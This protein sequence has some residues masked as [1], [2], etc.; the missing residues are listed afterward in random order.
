MSALLQALQFLVRSSHTEYRSI[1]GTV[2]LNAAVL[3]DTRIMNVSASTN[4]Y[5]RVIA[6]FAA[7]VVCAAAIV[8]GGWTDLAHGDARVL[9]RV[10]LAGS[11]TST[12]PAEYRRVLAG[13]A[14]GVTAARASAR[15]SPGAK[16]RSERRF[17]AKLE[18]G[19]NA[20]L[21]AIRRAARAVVQ[22][23][24]RVAAAVER[25][26]GQIDS[27]DAVPGTIVAWVPRAA[28]AAISRLPGVTTVNRTSRPHAMATALVDGA[29]TWHAAGFAGQAPNPDNA[30][31]D[32]PDVVV[33]DEGITTDHVAFNSR[34]PADCSTCAGT[35][36][37]KDPAH[38]TAGPH[39]RVFSAAGRTDFSG[40]PHG[41]TIAASIASTDFTVGCASCNAGL[42]FG[43]DNLY[44]TWQ[45]K[46]PGLWSLGLSYQGEPGVADLPEVF[47]YSAGIYN[48]TIGHDLSW[49]YV[50]GFVNDMGVQWVSSAGN[51]GIAGPGYNGCLNGMHRVSTPA[52]LF[53]VLSVGG[54]SAAIPSDTNSWTV[55]PNSST[56]PTWDGRKKPDLIARPRGNVSH[57]KHFDV[58]SNGKLD[59]YGNNGDGTSYAAP[60][61]VAG[62]ALLA[63][64]GIYSPIAQR[65]M[66]INTA[67]PIQG[68][69]YWTPTSGWGALNL[70]AAFHQRG[71]WAISQV[72]GAGANSA[73]FFEVT[74]VSAGDRTT[75]AWNRR[76]SLNPNPT[77][78]TTGPGQY[79]AL[80]NLDLSQISPADQ[81]GATVTSTGGS[82][83]A[84][85][86]DI[87]QTASGAPGTNAP[88]D[89]P[90]PGSGVDGE[91]NVEQI[92]S[93]SSGT[94]ILKVKAL[95]PIDGQATE[96]FALA[97]AKPIAALQTPI[98]ELTLEPS[99]TLTA[100][101]TQVTITTTVENPSNDLAL[102]GAI[103]TLGTLPA[104]VTAVGATSTALGTIAPAG[105]ASTTFTV[106]GA[107][108]GAAEISVTVAGTTYGEN[109]A[110]T[111]T[112]SITFDGTPPEIS[113][114]AL[115]Q[116]SISTA[117]T[118]TWSSTDAISGIDS[119]DAE[120]Q[121]AGGA[122]TTLVDA[123]GATSAQLSAPEGQTV[124]LRVRARDQVG[125]VSGWA[126]A[127]TTIDAVE[128][129]ISFGG[130]S[131]PS[132]GTLSVPTSVTNVGAPIVSSSYVF[133]VS[134]WGT[135]RPL[136]GSASYFNPGTRAL[137]V[138]LRVTATD[139]LG[140]TVTK[141]Q[142]YSAPPRWLTSDLSLR[143][144]K[145]KKRK[146]TVS[147]SVAS[148]YRGTVVVTVKRRGKVGTR[149][150]VKRVRAKSGRWSTTIKLKRGRYDVVA[151]VVRTGD[152]AA[153]SA[154]RS[155]VAVR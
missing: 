15:R 39:T 65:A 109:F 137:G 110:D 93:T 155:K 112:T 37:S 106:E 8:A 151:D 57:P 88:T 53:N 78:N 66:L 31:V 63:S 116:W 45:A 113:I 25:L 153:A 71:N 107:L 126:E 117:P 42:A 129:V 34:L 92:R 28:L 83:A 54:L 75:L 122:W 86:V 61:V 130:T 140:R 154:R 52:N 102:S 26:G 148:S 48:D 32:G 73:R 59:D 46:S 67:T 136:T 38:P 21:P 49:R 1:C 30:G 132:R 146:M 4:I 118:A 124:A 152:Y 5:R 44:D 121:V 94:Q 6:V 80:T 138:I 81:T 104:G 79:S 101:G 18:S 135:P 7:C 139:A 58:D 128:P 131:T 115:P 55:W 114:E 99:T 111:N 84:D 96:P 76:I 120:Q 69:T 12:V 10:E 19:R 13:R 123:G 133:S 74:G 60:Q 144:P 33:H 43:I 89:N 77:F 119:Y 62:V 24:E 142:A 105:S 16:T 51:C 143:K 147:G 72:H 141:S 134:G 150:V 95:S 22:R 50:D 145:V 27:S 149:R 29:P 108:D 41:N 23:Q 87:N 125:N 56:G 103:A 36:P 97:S 17:A 100:A 20:A 3:A 90:M 98:P 127:S 14:P 85:N 64:V 70:D 40:S 82:D 2:V 9:V 68:Q 11:P 35:G 91:D 47:N